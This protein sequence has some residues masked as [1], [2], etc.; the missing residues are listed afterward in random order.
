MK[1]EEERNDKKESESR[2]DLN[3]HPKTQRKMNR[4]HDTNV[5]KKKG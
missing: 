4:D 1:R 3:E 5:R 2:G